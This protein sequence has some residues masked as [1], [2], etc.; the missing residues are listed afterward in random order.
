MDEFLIENLSSYDPKSNAIKCKKPFFGHF[1]KLAN[2]LTTDKFN[3]DSDLM[4]HL[5]KN[6]EWQEFIVSN[7]RKINEIHDIE[8]GGHNPKKQKNF[9]KPADKKE[10]IDDF[11]MLFIDNKKTNEKHSAMFENNYQE[12]DLQDELTYSDLQNDLVNL[13]GN[14][15]FYLKYQP[16]EEE[17]LLDE[18]QFDLISEQMSSLNIKNDV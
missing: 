6:Q 15:N 12:A 10:E 17:N 4:K 14:G 13:E 5:G 16:E 8:L 18:C 9:P 2:L 11:D 1:L 3:S 7:L